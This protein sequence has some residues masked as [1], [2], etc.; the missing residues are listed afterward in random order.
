M[1]T[2]PRAPKLKPKSVI[3]SEI[4]INGVWVPHIPDAEGNLVPCDKRGEPLAP[5]PTAG[6]S[7]PL[8]AEASSSSSAAAP[9]GAGR[10]KR[11]R[12]NVAGTL[13]SPGP[14]DQLSQGSDFGSFDGSDE[15]DNGSKHVKKK[16]GAK[17]AAEKRAIAAREEKRLKKERAKDSERMAKDG[18]YDIDHFGVGERGRERAML[19]EGYH[20]LRDTIPALRFLLYV[21][22]FPF[23]CLSLTH[24]LLSFALS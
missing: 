2:K 19:N 10:T 23:I 5:P 9:T 6:S 24:Q 4:Q 16:V 1:P 15:I 13:S 12:T 21:D 7:F 22:P 3:I 8:N 14:D 20:D 17:S 11:K 18:T